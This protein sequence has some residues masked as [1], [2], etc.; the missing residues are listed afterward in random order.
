MALNGIKENKCFEP[1]YIP[2]RGYHLFTFIEA[3]A[4]ATFSISTLG[5]NLPSDTVPVVTATQV[6]LPG[7]SYN[8]NV[9]INSYLDLVNKQAV[10]VCK[11]NSSSTIGQVM[12]D[13]AIL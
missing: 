4:S 13:Y 3:G 8:E 10:I 11:N 2:V 12:V 7:D 6:L 1:T 5:M 9:V